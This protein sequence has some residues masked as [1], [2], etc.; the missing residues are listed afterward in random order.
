MTLRSVLGRLTAAWRNDMA[1]P[2]LIVS[3]TISIAGSPATVFGYDEDEY[4]Q[5]AEIHAANNPMLSRAL[6]ALPTDSVMI[7]AGANIGL[8]TVGALR[9]SSHVLRVIAIEPS[10]KA[11]ACLRQ[12]I[13]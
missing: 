4:Y 8:T 7:D 3:K 12:T 2:D 9:E 10:P 1:R 13:G 11:L 5:K 6:A